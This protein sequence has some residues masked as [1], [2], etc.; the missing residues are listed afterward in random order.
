MD[1]GDVK[2]GISA[3]QP[4]TSTLMDRDEESAREAH[5]DE[6]NE[7]AAQD[8]WGLR[9]F[10]QDEYDPQ[11]AFAA[12]DRAT[13]NWEYAPIDSDDDP[14]F[15]TECENNCGLWLSQSKPYH[16][17]TKK[18]TDETLSICHSCFGDH[19]WK[20]WKE[21]DDSTDQEEEEFD[22]DDEESST[23]K[24][25]EVIYQKQAKI[26]VDE[27]LP[28]LEDEECEDCDNAK[29]PTPK[30]VYITVRC[31]EGMWTGDMIA[32]RYAQKGVIASALAD[33]EVEPEGNL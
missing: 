19:D 33:E 24:T 26:V 9:D 25:M 12:F 21:G 28:P 8:A 6:V 4:A 20:S 29:C 16:R 30:T 23:P 3:V 18:G 32:S 1:C 2:I 27:D 15:L 7:M 17:M 31:P 10:G 22:S 11:E 14:E 5:E 13:Q